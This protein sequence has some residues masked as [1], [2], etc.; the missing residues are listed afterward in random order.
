MVRKF[1]CIAI[2]ILYVRCESDTILNCDTVSCAPPPSLV[3]QFISIETGEDLFQNGTFQRESLQVEDQDGNSIQFRFDESEMDDE[4]V[5]ID[6]QGLMT[7]NLEITPRVY[8]VFVE[9]EFDFIVSFTIQRVSGSSCCDGY[10][11]E[12]VDFEGIDFTTISEEIFSSRFRVL[13]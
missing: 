3:L 8:R 5:F 7:E 11:L 9:D 2:F 13:L 1:F 4:F 12:N 6:S 10:N